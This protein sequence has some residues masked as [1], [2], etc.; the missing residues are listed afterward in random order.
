VLRRDISIP[1]DVTILNHPK[2]EVERCHYERSEAILIRYPKDC[3]APFGCN[4][5][6]LSMIWKVYLCSWVRDTPGWIKTSHNL[7]ERRNTVEKIVL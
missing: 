4:G 1:P 5:Q 3:R 6:M 2:T 7:A